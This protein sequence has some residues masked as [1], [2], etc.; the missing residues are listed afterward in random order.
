MVVD[1][2]GRS[3]S[4]VVN[5]EVPHDT[6]ALG[7]RHPVSSFG[8]GRGPAVNRQVPYDTS[9]PGHGHEVSTFGEGMAA[10]KEEKEHPQPWL[11]TVQLKPEASEQVC[12]EQQQRGDV[13]L[14]GVQQPTG[15]STSCPHPLHPD[16][17]QHSPLH[18]SDV[19]AASGVSSAAAEVP[20]VPLKFLCQVA[21]MLGD[22]RGA[23]EIHNHNQHAPQHLVCVLAT[24]Y[25]MLG[26]KLIIE[27]PTARMTVHVHE[28]VLKDLF[29]GGGIRICKHHLCVH[30]DARTDHG[31]GC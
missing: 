26:D 30:D 18:A 13:D 27:D 17:P 16:Q 29:E 4:G 19:R 9:D 25:S 3:Q 12:R 31:I 24:V 14:Q 23:P 15:V 1:E 11:Q 28:A 5:Q 6:S 8:E 2:G 10:V 7:N 21:A 22:Q 20:Q